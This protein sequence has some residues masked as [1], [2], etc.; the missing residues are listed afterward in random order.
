M[1]EPPASTGKPRDETARS[2]RLAAALRANLTR[3]K[4]QVRAREAVH[5]GDRDGSSGGDNDKNEG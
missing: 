4:A 2:E 5:D 1:R 3:R